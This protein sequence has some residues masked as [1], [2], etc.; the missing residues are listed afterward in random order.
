VYETF[1][2]GVAV[3]SLNVAVRDALEQAVPRGYNRK[4]KF[5]R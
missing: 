2:V 4:S 3:A 5:P 1:S